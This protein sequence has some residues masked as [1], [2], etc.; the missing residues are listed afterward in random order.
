MQWYLAVL[1]SLYH[2]FSKDYVARLYTPS[3]FC[4][5]MAQGYM[6][7]YGHSISSVNDVLLTCLCLL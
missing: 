1:V 2:C 7:G 5:V 3:V 6:Y 4:I